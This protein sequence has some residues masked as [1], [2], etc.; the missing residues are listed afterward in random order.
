M[1]KFVNG[2]NRVGIYAS[3]RIEEHSELFMDY[4]YDDSDTEIYGFSKY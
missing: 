1:I 3:K 4:R 2:E